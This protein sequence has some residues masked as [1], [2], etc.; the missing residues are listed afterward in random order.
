MEYKFVV[1]N[2]DICSEATW[3]VAVFDNEED[4]TTFAA[5]VIGG[6]VDRLVDKVVYIKSRT[7]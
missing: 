1:S 7:E 6:E 4:A 3:P 5:T 2:R